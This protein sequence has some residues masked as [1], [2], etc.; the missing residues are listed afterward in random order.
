MLDKFVIAS[1]LATLRFVSLEISQASPRGHLE[2]LGSHRPAE[3]TVDVVEEFPAPQQFY[4]NYVFPAKPFLVK[5]GARNIPAFSLWT[6][7]YLRCGRTFLVFTFVTPTEKLKSVLPGGHTRSSQ[8]QVGELLSL[9]CQ[10]TRMVCLN[11]FCRK[12][13]GS[14]MVSIELGKK[15]ERGGGQREIRLSTYLDIY[16]EADMY[17]VSDVSDTMKGDV[18]AGSLFTLHFLYRSFRRAKR[19][20]VEGSDESSPLHPHTHTQTNSSFLCEP[21]AIFFACAQSPKVCVR[22]CVCVFTPVWRACGGRS[23]RAHAI[24]PTLGS[25]TRPVLGGNLR[26]PPP[27][28]WTD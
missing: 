22:V 1:K 20:T 12:T 10:T 16:R 17:M 18:C 8:W 23:S 9:V 3:G 6:D 2:P 7:D 14:E 27:S 21:W 5:N 28:L 13:Y 4:D 19:K 15:E 26:P 25:S 24:P 11:M